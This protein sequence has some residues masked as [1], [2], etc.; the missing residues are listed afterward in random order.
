MLCI[1]SGPEPQRSIFES[2]L[3]EQLKDVKGKVVLVRG[4]PA[5]SIPLNLPVNISVSDHLHADE[6][7]QV[8]CNSD[9]VIARSGYSTVMDLAKLQKRAIL[10][11]TP[12]Q[13]EQEYLAEYLFEN[14]YVVTFQAGDFNLRDA[15]NILSGTKLLPFPVNDDG[16]LVAA[17]QTL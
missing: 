1:I 8:M 14:N 16:L 17:I 11:P 7:N 13:S 9:V 2:L 4:L 5:G 3:V 12:G 6:L 15:L 10:I